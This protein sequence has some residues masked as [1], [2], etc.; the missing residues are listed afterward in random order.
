[1]TSDHVS[2][3]R[4]RTWRIVLSVL[5]GGVGLWVAVTLAGGL[6]DS[7]E[8]VRGLDPRWLL[9][10]VAA[11]AVSYLALGL[12]LRR[13]A[14]SPGLTRR[15]AMRVALVVFG[16]GLITPASPAEGLALGAVELRR[17]G[18]RP[19]RIAVVLGFSEGYSWA[20]LYLL[21]A[22]NA[23]AAAAVGDLHGAARLPI[24]LAAVGALGLI[25]AVGLLARRRATAEWLA[26]AVDA[27]QFWR[28]RA[29][30]EERRHV[31]AEWH[32]EAM[33]AIGT[34][35]ERSILVG[36]AAGAWIADA[37]C[38][39]FALLAAGV[40]VDLDVL[41]LAYTAGIIATSVPL[42]PA[43]IG[44]VEAVI[45]AVLHGFGVPY[46]DALAAALAYRVLGT[47]LPAAAGALALAG[48]HGVHPHTAADGSSEPAV[49]IDLEADAADAAIDRSC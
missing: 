49:R 4:R 22:L 46:R 6:A 3:R 30:V 26:V 7:V 21:A 8:A 24:V 10:G 27:L 36:L 23:L 12:Q 13:L 29:P 38:L 1:M 34:P 19:R 5:I 35:G 37:A 16:L 31:G 33:Q 42:L 15:T 9:L 14:G 32:A 47:F 39:F 2:A 18:V 40:H 25:V 11:E 43:G 48:L 28:P 17:R 45:P 20:A 44:V 41:L